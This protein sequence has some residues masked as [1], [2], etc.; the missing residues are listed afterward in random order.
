MKRVKIGELE[1]ALKQDKKMF[2]TI[3][4]DQNLRVQ[5]Q[6]DCKRFS[7]WFQLSKSRPKNVLQVTAA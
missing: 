2:I 4:N 5:I 7:N 1:Y 3:Q 6:A